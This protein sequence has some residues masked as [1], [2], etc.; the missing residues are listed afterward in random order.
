MA[1]AAR[2]ATDV[3]DLSFSELEEKLKQDTYERLAQ[4]NPNVSSYADWSAD[5]EDLKTRIGRM[6]SDDREDAVVLEKDENGVPVTTAKGVYQFVNAAVDTAKNRFANAAKR[7]DLSTEAVDKLP[8]DPREW[9][10]SASD[11]VLAANIFEYG[12]NPNDKVKVGS[13][14]YLR[15]LGGPKSAEAQ[16]DIYTQIHHTNVDT[17]TLARMELPR[18][19]GSAPTTQIASVEEEA[20]TFSPQTSVA[21]VRRAKQTR[22]D[23]V[24]PPQ[25]DIEQ[26]LPVGRPSLDESPLAMAPVQMDDVPPASNTMP[27]E[28][29]VEAEEAIAQIEAEIE[30]AEIEAAVAQIAAVEPTAVLPQEEEADIE[31]AEIE[32]AVAQVEAEEPKAAQ[33]AAV[34]PTAVLPQEEVVPEGY[35]RVDPTDIRTAGLSMAI[36]DVT[37][38]DG[39]VYEVNGPEDATEAQVIGYVRRQIAEEERLAELEPDFID[40][41]EEFGKGIPSGA[42]GLFESAALGGAALLSDEN[43]ESARETIQSVAAS[44][45]SP[46]SADEGSEDAVGRKFGEAT[47]SFVGLGATALLPYV[48]VPAAAALAAGA[49]AGEARERARAGGAT[50]DERATVTG[51]GALV[52]LS[53]LIPLVKFKALRDGIGENTL[54]LVIDRVKRAGVAAGFEGAQEAAAGIAQNL[55]EQGIYNPEQGT[56]TGTGEAFGYGAGVGGLVQGLLDLAAPRRRGPNGDSTGGTD[57]TTEPSN[58]TRTGQLDLF[59][60]EFNEVNDLSEASAEG[61]A[62]LEAEALAAAVEGVS[63]ETITLAG[64][65]YTLAQVVNLPRSA[66]AGWSEADQAEVERVQVEVQTANVPALLNNNTPVEEYTVEQLEAVRRYQETA[67][68]RGATGEGGVG[69]D[70]QA[71]DAAL[72]LPSAPE[73][74][75]A[76]QPTGEGSVGA[77]TAETTL[78]TEEAIRAVNV[79]KVL[80]EKPVEERSDIELEAVKRFEQEVVPTEETTD[81]GDLFSGTEAESTNPPRF[82]KDT[83]KDFPVPYTPPLPEGVTA[84]DVEASRVSQ[85]AAA[86]RSVAERVAKE[87]QLAA[88]DAA[89]QQVTNREQYEADLV[90]DTALGMMQRKADD[91]FPIELDQAGGAAQ[92]TQEGG[93]AERARIEAYGQAPST[94]AK[95]KREVQ[96]YLASTSP[97]ATAEPV[98]QKVTKKFLGDLF[99]PPSSTFY[100]RMANRELTADELR[101]RIR[102][103]GISLNTSAKAKRAIQ[104]YLSSPQNPNSALTKLTPAAQ[105][106]MEFQTKRRTPAQVAAAKKKKT[107]ERQRVAKNAKAKE[108]RAEKKAAKT[109][110]ALVAEKLI[111]EGVPEDTAVITATGEGTTK[112]SKKLKGIASFMGINANPELDAPLNEDT[113]SLLKAGKVKEALLA[114]AKALPNTLEFAAIKANARALAQKVGDTKVVIVSQNPTSQIERIYRDTLDEGGANGAYSFNSKIAE[115]SNVILLDSKI[116][117]TASTFL[118]EMTHATTHSFI[119]TNPNSPYVKALRKMYAI[120]IIYS[121]NGDT[122]YGLTDVHEFVSEA[123]SN[124]AFQEQLSNVPVNGLATSEGSVGTPVSIWQRLKNIFHNILNA[125]TDRTVPINSARLSDEANRVISLILSP[126]P[127]QQGVGVLV[128]SA[129][130]PTE[131]ILRQVNQAYRGASLTP[132]ERAAW[133]REAYETFE[134]SS[135]VSQKVIFKMLPMQAMKDFAGYYSELLGKAAGKLNTLMLNQRGDLS[136]ADA[137]SVATARQIKNW[138]QPV[139]WNPASKKSDERIAEIAMLD[140]IAGISTVEEVDPRLTK[141]QAEKEYGKGSAKMDIWQSMRKDWSAIGSEGREV[142]NLMEKTYAVLYK[143]L[144]TSLESR[145]NSADI[146][147]ETRQKLKGVYKKMLQRRKSPY[148]PLRRSGKYRLAFEAF[149]KD[150]NSTEPVFLMFETNIDRKDYIDRVLAEDRNVVRKSDNS[151]KVDTYNTEKGGYRGAAP[152]IGFINDLLKAIP[153]GGK[154]S[155]AMEDAIIEGFINALPQTSFAKGFQKRQNIA[156]FTGQFTGEFANNIYDLNRKIVRMDYSSKLLDIQNEISEIQGLTIGGEEAKKSLIERAEFARNPPADAWAQA[157]NR[158]AFLFTIGFNASSALVNLS[159]LPLVIYPMLAGRYGPVEASRAMMAASGMITR[160]GFSKETQPLVSLKGIESVESRAMPSIT[161]MFTTD[162]DGNF[163]IRKG[164]RLSAERRVALEALIPLVKVATATNALVSTSLLD[165]TG[166]NQ[167]SANQSVMDLVTTGSAFMFH[168]VEQY[169]RQVTLIATYNLELARV[170]KEQPTL[171]SQSQMELAAENSLLRTQEY[172]GGTVL[173][174][175][176]PFAQKSVGRVGLMYKGFGIQMYYTLLKATRQFMLGTIDGKR[177]GDNFWNEARSEAFKQLMGIHG[178]ALFF[179][180]VQGLPI[181]GSIALIANLFVLDDDEDS[182]EEL[183][184]KAIGSEAWYKGFASAL[185]GVDVS[186]RVALTNLVLQSNRYGSDDKTPEELIVQAISGPAGSVA[187]QGVRGF[188]EAISGD[189]PDSLRRGIE[190][191]TPAAIKNGLKAARYSEEDGILTRRK[192]PILEDVTVGQLFAQIAGFAPSDY[193]KNQEEVRNIKSIDTALRKTRSKLLRKNNLA[194]FY[195]DAEEQAAVRKEIEAYNKRISKNFPKARITMGTL[196]RSRRAFRTQTQRMV[197]GVQL[198]ESVRRPLVDF[199]E[200]QI[201]II[202]DFED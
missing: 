193:T 76:T 48:G 187:L 172:N 163:V 47:G 179:S 103:Y 141:S 91:L 28:Y 88:V 121:E 4:N 90:E 184:R 45:R 101:S 51:L 153:S 168:S 114:T 61:E 25:T 169:N 111:K 94:P 99:I 62:A 181:Y 96:K 57:E 123:F 152:S 186:Q 171:T 81:T 120:A 82:T 14:T 164:L 118:H 178:S 79:P 165:Y 30:A 43:E 162:K 67:D 64:R 22:P 74:Y 59:D 9:S 44:A 63:A 134:G 190:R 73:S 188:Q 20:P 5:W 16:R 8:A 52:G 112:L 86:E 34:E 135:R 12:G 177:K 132:S 201:A 170:K 6:E 133:N 7:L 24:Q 149:N 107:Q 194:R 80:A 110:E 26:D 159:Q 130:Y 128:D 143:K 144:V 136:E 105:Q 189:G 55:I 173:E 95:A 131:G 124:P 69:A 200:D 53:E 75:P 50:Y 60:D 108:K 156:G 180:G 39:Q 66:I 98:K 84:E 196:G 35:T 83:S 147:P 199:M 140:N 36:Y 185:L 197:N 102:V 106:S 158:Y 65:E 160:S 40:Q 23:F 87:E 49:G 32:A 68:S 58:D 166:V 31:A 21:E 42:I 129:Q 1:I 122:A 175:A 150:T 155:Q 18:H 113:I 38:P 77:E 195:G 10:R 54:A 70:V 19:F 15:E 154:E 126:A 41:I 182:F 127:G 29:E 192:D 93:A 138:T 71:D 176:S 146:G 37:G 78:E 183:T 85:E 157:A 117:L 119:E 11:L 191:M 116:G 148:F 33:I 92:T 174:T 27:T 46:F 202:S 109:A 115:L 167:G 72:T 142:Y 17:P 13:D 125:G 137:V 104:D 56:F 97:T 139:W 100:K 161:N 3:G 2:K 145:L 198:S 89:N 151:P